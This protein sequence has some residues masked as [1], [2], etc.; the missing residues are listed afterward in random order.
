MEEQVS[1]S[2][3]ALREAIS[4]RY[5]VR[6]LSVWAEEDRRRERS[7]SHRQGGAELS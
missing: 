7:G 1:V 4:R 5:G 2:I 3:S 6:N